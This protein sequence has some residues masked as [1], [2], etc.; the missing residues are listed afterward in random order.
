MLNVPFWCLISKN[1]VRYLTCCLVSVCMVGMG[2]RG[3]IPQKSAPWVN[4]GF[5]RRCMMCINSTELPWGA[6]DAM[7]GLQAMAKDLQPQPASA[8]E[9]R[10]KLPRIVT[11]G[12]IRIASELPLDHR[13]SYLAT[14]ALATNRSLFHNFCCSCLA[15]LRRS[16]RS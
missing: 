14:C 4:E 15:F 13:T 9:R 2:A 12:Y 16:L 7:R 8:L 6:P 1:R 10:R 5:S 11:A 3:S